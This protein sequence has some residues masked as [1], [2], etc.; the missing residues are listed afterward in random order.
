MRCNYFYKG[1][2]NFNCYKSITLAEMY[3]V[4]VTPG[5][6]SERKKHSSD[7]DSEIRAYGGRRKESISMK[8]KNYIR[9]Q[10]QP[11]AISGE[12]KKV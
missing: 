11:D 2:V 7:M 8:L 3:S 12:S 10:F 1:S 6:S 9:S 4:H 5:R